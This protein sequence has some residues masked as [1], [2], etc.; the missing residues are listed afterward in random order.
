MERFWGG[1]LLFWVLHAQREGGC[2]CVCG[3]ESR[4]LEEEGGGGAGR[5]QHGIGQ[6]R[7]LRLSIRPYSPVLPPAPFGSCVLGSWWAR[8]G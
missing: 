3:G 8:I 4:N 5:Y 2:A 1:S 7:N 6:A